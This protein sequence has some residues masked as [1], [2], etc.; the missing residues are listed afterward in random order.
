MGNTCKLD[1]SDLFS[2]T[3][4]LGQAMRGICGG[5]VGGVKRLCCGLCSSEFM[6]HFPMTLFCTTSFSHVCV[7]EKVAADSGLCGGVQAWMLPM[8]S[9]SWSGFVGFNWCLVGDRIGAPGGSGHKK[10]ACNAGDQVW[11]L[12]QKDPP[13]E[14][15][16]N[17][18]QYSCLENTLDGGAWKATVHGVT[19]GQTRL[20]DITFSF[21]LSGNRRGHESVPFSPKGRKWRV[22][23]PQPDI[24]Y[25]LQ[26]KRETEPTP[27]T[28]ASGGRIHG[29]PISLRMGW[30]F[31][32]K[33]RP[34][35][36]GGSS[37][38][39]R[40]EWAGIWLGNPPFGGPHPVISRTTFTTC[41]LNLESNLGLLSAYSVQVVCQG[42][43]MG[44]FLK[45]SQQL[46]EDIWFLVVKDEKSKL[47]G[48]WS[49][50]LQGLHPQWRCGMAS[51]SV[52]SFWK[53]H[54]KRLWKSS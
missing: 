33:H 8:I 28:R 39:F 5:N 52:I 22:L 18:H 50:G 43:N 36:D 20:S 25:G 48:P 24:L 21:F 26:A 27:P 30:N 17:P 29:R 53:L 40:S 1:L 6:P 38:T 47:W 34:G 49:G 3:W 11:S 12:G 16:G 44:R 19:K 15:N 14:G 54:P 4:F 51:P 37:E 31:L 41:R 32:H 13:G 42:M 9:A 45:P 7:A 46:L 23:I 10:S 35:S 2:W